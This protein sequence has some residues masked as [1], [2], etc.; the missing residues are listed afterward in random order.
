[1]LV[2]VRGT[3]RPSQIGQRKDA[4]YAKQSPLDR[5]IDLAAD[6]LRAIALVQ[7]GCDV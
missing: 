6:R 5:V 2:E 7:F 4:K 1:M 3:V